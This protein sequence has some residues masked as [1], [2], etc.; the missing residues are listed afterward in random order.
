MYPFPAMNSSWRDG[1]WQGSS[2]VLIGRI[3]LRGHRSSLLPS[4]KLLPCCRTLPHSN[5]SPHS[6]HSCNDPNEALACETEP[7]IKTRFYDIKV[8]VTDANGLEGTDVCSVVVVPEKK[9]GYHRELSHTKPKKPAYE[10][11]DDP[12]EFRDLFK[13]SH[14]A[15]CIA[16]LAVEWDPTKDTTLV[17]PYSEKKALL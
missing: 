4:R 3:L 15:W 8:T 10:K 9:K 11:Y 14:H 1:L 17:K 16:E 6:L 7:Y 2:S 12:N 5:H 13:K